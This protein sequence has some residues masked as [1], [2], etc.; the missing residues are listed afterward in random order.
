MVLDGR[1]A[2]LVETE[3]HADHLYVVNVAVRPDLRGLGLGPRLMAHAEGVARVA[4]LGEMRLMTNQRMSANIALYR[5]LG[6]AVTDEVPFPHGVAVHMAKTL[7]RPARRLLFLPGAGGDPGFWKPLGERLPLEWRKTY[8]GWP[9]LGAQPADPT[10]AGW[11]DLIAR[12]EAELDDGPVDLLAQSMGGWIAM[13]VLLRHPDK[14][15]RVVLSVTSAGVDMAALGASDWRPAYRRTNPAA[16]PWITGE[17][18]D[19]AARL[20]AAG[21]RTLLLWEDADPISPVAV[22]ERLLSLLPA[23][24]LHVSPGADHAHV[25]TRAADLAP[26]IAAHLGTP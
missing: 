9:G 12:V 24:D 3:A 17:V 6:Y 22:G 19:L 16:A 8:F 20:S 15:R 10:V 23:A 7:A 11:E 1:L 14:V 18:E 25:V 2:G 13:Q 26:L 4:G 5:R 21:Q